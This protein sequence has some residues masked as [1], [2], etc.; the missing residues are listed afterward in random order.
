MSKILVPH[1][2]RPIPVRAESDSV[3]SDTTGSSLL[4]RHQ[5]EGPLPV[6]V[7]I[8]Q[9][10]QLKSAKH[11]AKTTESCQEETEVQTESPSVKKLVELTQ[12]RINSKVDEATKA[13]IEFMD[14]KRDIKQARVNPLYKRTQDRKN[15]KK[16]EDT[17]VAKAKSPKKTSVLRKKFEPEVVKA[18]TEETETKEERSTIDHTP[19]RSVREERSKFNRGVERTILVEE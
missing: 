3:S 13:P 16:V 4:K 14:T 10:F 6:P 2:L 5:Y 11:E 15:V 7:K 1:H 17:D 8:P 18:S 19:L 9:N 12:S